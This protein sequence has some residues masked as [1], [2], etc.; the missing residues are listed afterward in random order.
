M[1]VL[2]VITKK[3]VQKLHEKMKDSVTMFF[4]IFVS[5]N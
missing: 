3:S 4:I 5:S 1:M 2:P